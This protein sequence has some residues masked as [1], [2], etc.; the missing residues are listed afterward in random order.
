MDKVTDKVTGKVT[1]KV[2]DK[3]NM[4]ILRRK[5]FASGDVAISEN[6]PTGE[7]IISSSQ[8][9]ENPGSFVPKTITTK[10]IE[11]EGNFFAVKQD[12]NGQVL[13]TEY[14]DLNLSATGNP[15]EAF[16][17]QQ[18]NAL[19][20]KVGI[21]GLGLLGLGIT[22]SPSGG[23]MGSALGNILTRSLKYSP[24]RATK[25]TGPGRTASGQYT[26][27][28][29]FDPRS[30]EY[31]INPV[32]ASVLGGTTVIGASNFAQTDFD[33]VE[34]E[35]LEL[36]EE[37]TALE[38]ISQK[39]IDNK[40]T[41]DDTKFEIETS[42]DGTPEG[43]TEID[44]NKEQIEETKET[45]EIRQQKISNNSNFNN[46]IRNIG[47][48][49]V[50]TG[51]IGEGISQGS[52]TTVK[53]QIAAE[54]A[55]K[56]AYLESLKGSEFDEF[57]AKQKIKNTSGSKIAEQTNKLAESVSDIEQGQ[58]T[59]QMFES[60]INIMDKDDITGLAPITKSLVN[61][62]TG[63]FNPDISLSP[64]ERAIVVLEQIAN[65]NIKTITGESGRTISNVDRQIAQRLVGDLK[66]PLTRETEVR[67]KIETQINTVNQRTSKALNEYRAT[68]LYFTENGLPVPLLPKDFKR[69]TDDKESRIRIKI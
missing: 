50:E 3:V 15:V 26:S 67:E 34:E 19:L 35:K 5:M 27:R 41:I 28:S 61:Q 13:D 42:I 11:K 59:L 20:D 53:E 64:R 31:K 12:T 66:N 16:Q 68:S 32:S 21:G 17:R 55:E 38:A 60:I 52:V 6:M 48:S 23:R 36:A 47:I 33:D 29:S 22:K 62:V 46:L 40:T 69:A 49:L 65:G 14:I 9:L 39:D 63:L 18:S 1:G 58:I 10:I 56:K 4:N 57:L 37:I 54:A 30:Y 7:K 44:N 2:T 43:T 25:L 24:V 45:P 51:D 8:G